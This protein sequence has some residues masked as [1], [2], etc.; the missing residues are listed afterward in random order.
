MVTQSSIKGYRRGRQIRSAITL[1][2]LV[3]IL[4]GAAWF[5]WREV[6]GDATPDRTIE[7]TTPKPGTKQRIAAQDVT[8]NVYNAGST[9]G[10]AND[11]AQQLRER[12]FQIGLVANAQDEAADVTRLRIMGRANDAPE[13]QLLAAHVRKP[14]R[15]PDSRQEPEV[16]LILGDEFD[17]LV[18]DG[19]KVLEVET[20]VA[21]CTTTT[22]S[23]RA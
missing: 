6:L 15:V 3:G 12:G 4:T 7:C 20:T 11:I 8:V 22:P 16:D 17:G 2:F 5:G 13:V 18:K 9:T 1:L 14:E 21:T 19:P 23:P 10:L